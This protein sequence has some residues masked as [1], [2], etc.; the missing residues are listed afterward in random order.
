MTTNQYFIIGWLSLLVILYIVYQYNL[1]IQAK[2]SVKEMYASIDVALKTRYDLIPN[3]IESI[4]AYM[5]YEAEVLIEITKARSRHDVKD[6]LSQNSMADEA[7][8]S[9]HIDKLLVTAEAYPDLKASENFLQLQY[10]LSEIEDRL[11]AVRRAYNASIRELNNF[12]EQIPTNIIAKLI[13][14]PIYPYFEAAIHEK[15]NIDI[16]EKIDT[17]AD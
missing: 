9:S 8:L 6:I 12:Q 11:Q 13:S 17:S 16:Q 15:E 14:I 7:V 10:Q 4:K 1:I 5:K 3:L 2:N